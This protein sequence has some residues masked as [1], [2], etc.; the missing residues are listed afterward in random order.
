MIDLSQIIKPVL[1]EFERFRD[2]FS[3]VIQNEIPLLEK[4]LLHVL[5]SKGKH[6]RPLLLLLTAKATGKISPTTIDSSVLIEV[7]HTTTLIHDDVVDDTKQRRGVPS[8]NAIFDNRIAVLTGDF[9]LAGTMIKAVETG[10]LT[11]IRIIA[12][13]CRELSEGE[14]MQLD[15]AENHSLNEEKYLSVIHKKTAT[16]ISACTEIGAIS[17]HAPAETTD[18]CR[19]F[20]KYLGYCF[21]IK[22]DIFDYYEDIKIGKPTG[23]DIREGKISLPLLFALKN[24]EEKDRICYMDI[25]NRQDFTTENVS[26]L[27][28]FAKHHGGIEYAEKRLI[29]YKQKAVEIISGFPASEARN[30]LLLMADYFSERAY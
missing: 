23:N 20:G 28:S 17:V 27:I 30:S 2:N 10:N 3:K 7:L 8:L 11:T 16:L 1:P 19:Q 12:Q 22:D 6:V 24:A 18:K 5:S 13:V 14:L 9:L 15:N 26:A 21:Q 25:I 4:A 29:D